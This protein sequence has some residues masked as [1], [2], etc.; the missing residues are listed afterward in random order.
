MAS[1]AEQSRSP[2]SDFFGRLTIV[3]VSFAAVVGQLLPILIAWKFAGPVANLLAFVLAL[4]IIGGA[5]LAWR[6]SERRRAAATSREQRAR[7]WA[8]RPLQAAFRGLYSYTRHDELPGL[9]RRQLAKL[10]ATQVAHPTFRYGVVCGEVGAGKSSLVD[11]GIGSQLEA[12]GFSI[13]LVRGLQGFSGE[14]TLEAVLE[15][16]RGQLHDATCEPVLILDQFEEILINWRS[17]EARRQLGEFLSQPLVDR[18]VQSPLLCAFRLSDHAPRSSPHL[19]DPTSSKT[20]F[21]VKNLDEQEAA[22]V[23]LECAGRDGVGIERMF[24]NTI[25]ADL[26]HQGQVRPPE[27]QLVCVALEG[28][29]PEKSYRLRGGAEGILSAY[30]GD[31]VTSSLAPDLARLALRGLCNFAVIPPA[32][33]QSKSVMQIAETA[34]EAARDADGAKRLEIV[35]GQLAEAGL[36]A[37]FVQNDQRTYA[38]VHDYLVQPIAFATSDTTTKSERATQLLRLHL[39]EY[40]ADTKSRIPFRRLRLIR[41]Y[42]DRELFRSASAQR[43]T[44][45]SA[46]SSFTKIALIG[47]ALVLIGSAVGAITKFVQDRFEMMEREFAVRESQARLFQMRSRLNELEREA[48]ATRAMLARELMR[49]GERRETEKAPPN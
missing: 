39:T 34:G 42:A 19:T 25:A 31:A 43:L 11:S 35:L 3:Q 38:L 41:R 24:A 26:S 48:S 18:H 4:T 12:G 2:T 23:I 32:K 40:A 10:I 36:L 6:Q 29:T 7:E 9:R 17:D 46:R 1:G 44:R 33:T 16:L 14:R 27:L 30:V 45:L 21:P 49:L 15:A 47:V 8:Q 37:V 20:L 28:S 22:E 13:T 5:F